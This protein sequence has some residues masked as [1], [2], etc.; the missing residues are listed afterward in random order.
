V[1]RLS[2]NRV[3]AL[4]ALH[5]IVLGVVML[6][7]PL[8]VLSA[9]GWDFVETRFY[10]AQ[11]GLFLLILGLVYAAA[12]RV[13]PYVAIVVLSKAFAVAFLL[14]EASRGSCPPVVFLTAGI[15]AVMGLLVA[16]AWWRARVDHPEVV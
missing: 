15:D 12:I 1:N 7:W 8:Q 10:P 16:L 9:F 11:S 3:L 14:V 2:L 5:S 6:V 13:R 4:V